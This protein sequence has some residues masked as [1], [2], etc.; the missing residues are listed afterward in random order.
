MYDI[1]EAATQMAVTGGPLAELVASL[2]ISVDTVA[3]QQQEIK[4][5]LKQI[6]ELKK[7]GASVPGGATVPGGDNI[8]CKNYEAVGQTAP[9]RRSVCYF[10]PRKNPE[11]KYWARRL[12]EEKR[13]KFNDE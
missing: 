10:H 7:K 12:M 6:S 4:R 2:A 13:L 1:A 9:H 8:I 11:I 3:R 5:L